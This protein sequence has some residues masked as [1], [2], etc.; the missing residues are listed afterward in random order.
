MDH[1][2]EISD[3]FYLGTLGR[4][5]CFQLEKEA[6]AGENFKLVK[7]WE[8]NLKGM[9]HFQVFVDLFDKYELLVVYTWGNVAGLNP[10]NGSVVM[11]N[12]RSHRVPR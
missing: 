2:K 5:A 7:L 3:S 1:S 8:N 6:G 12:S 10:K 4:V 11:L 9:G